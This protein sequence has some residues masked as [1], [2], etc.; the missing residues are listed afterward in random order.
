VGRATFERLV[1]GRQDPDHAAFDR[2]VAHPVYAK[3][4]WIS[5]L[6]PSRETVRTTLMPLIA[7]GHDRLARRGGG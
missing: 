4:R 5:I 6:N 7:A 2:F 3:Q 1:G